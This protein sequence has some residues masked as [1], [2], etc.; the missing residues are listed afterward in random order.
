MEEKT[1][2]I[3]EVSK[4]IT[5]IREKLDMTKVQMANEL[6]ISK[7]TFY[8]LELANRKLQIEELK[9]LMDKFNIS[10]AWVISGEGEMLVEN[11]P[12]KA[13]LINL[14]LDFRQY[15][16]EVDL[17]RNEIIKVILGKLFQTEKLF[18][19]IP[20]PNSIFGDHVPYSLMKLLVYSNF[21]DNEQNAKNY[22]RDQIESLDVPWF[23][24]F[25]VKKTL[26]SLL[27]KIDNKDCFYLLKCRDIAAKQLL[28]NI[29]RFNKGFNN[30]LIKED[31][32]L[33][34][35]IKNL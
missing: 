2:Y 35:I 29:S 12:K 28:T 17:V 4:R 7:Q 6:S 15:G 5:K 1:K 25:E 22:F 8:T 34:K 27:E 33:H 23:V 26:Y 13:Q 10:P 3:K 20:L 16:G 30:L 32:E 18:K 14:I 9:N 31:R 24:P 21:S 19:I 11:D